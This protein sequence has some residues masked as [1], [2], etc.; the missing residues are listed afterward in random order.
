MAKALGITDLR[1]MQ[2]IKQL[3]YADD[4]VFIA[5]SEEQLQTMTDVLAKFCEDY[6]LEINLKKNK[7]EVMVVYY[8]PQQ[9]KKTKGVTP[10]IKFR[11]QVFGV[12]ELPLL[13]RVD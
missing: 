8:S 9:K 5:D 6:R 2:E 11:D 7:S 4:I 1:G 13:G 3:L 10:I 12:T